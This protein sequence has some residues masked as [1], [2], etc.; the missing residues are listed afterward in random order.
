MAPEAVPK[1]PRKNKS[2]C[3]GVKQFGFSGISCRVL[4]AA[5]PLVCGSVLGIGLGKRH[6]WM[7][8]LCVFLKK[9]HPG[10]WHIP[11]NGQRS[12]GPLGLRAQPQNPPPRAR[13]EQHIPVPWDQAGGWN[14]QFPLLREPRGHGD[15]AGEVTQVPPA[16]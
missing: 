1:T 13:D 12:S 10:G 14:W 4:P 16:P 11:G 7:W 5:F 2:R 8:D 9:V 6:F 3:S 15:G